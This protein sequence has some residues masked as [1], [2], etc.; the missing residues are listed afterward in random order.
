MK[1]ILTLIFAAFSVLLLVSCGLLGEGAGENDIVIWA[2]ADYWGGTNGE[3][4]SEFLNI[5]TE[6]TGTR[7]IF[8]PQAD[9]DTR[10]KSAAIDGESPDLVIWD[11]WETVRYIRENRF[12]K[13][14]DYMDK[15]GVSIDEFQQAA[16]REMMSGEDIYGLPLDV[17]AWGFWINKT[18]LAEAGITKLPRTWDEFEAAAIAMTRYSDPVNKT[19]MTRA[20]MNLNISGLFY[21]FLQTAGGEILTVDANGKPIPAFNSEYGEAVLQWWY[22]LVHTHK[23][24]DFSFGASS[25][26]GSVDDPFL[27]QKVA[28]QAN[29]LLNGSSFYETYSDGSFEY[30]FVPFPMG[31]SSKFATQDNPAASNAGGLMGGFGLAIPV[32][33]KKQDLAWDLME[34]WLTDLDNVVKWSEISKLIPA[35]LEVINDPKMKE[36][37]NVRNVIDVLDSLRTRPQTPGYTSIETGVIMPLIDGFLFEGAYDRGNPTTIDKVRAVLKHMETQA[38]EILEF[39]NR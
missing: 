18:L 39:E 19:G 3:I 6:E 25:Q 9:L 21:S 29:S 33:S 10:L 11:R 8:A 15:A 34:Y 23:V 26:G 30:E 28:M 35:K 20:G 37:P 36:I 27:T 5:Y 38:K 14:N 12:V 22:E 1:K 32:T 24:Y 13:I 2:N 7:V 16:A 31:P 4:V 17:D